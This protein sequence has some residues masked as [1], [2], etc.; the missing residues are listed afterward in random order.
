MSVPLSLSAF[1]LPPPIPVSDIATERGRLLKREAIALVLGGSLKTT[2]PYP[3][4]RAEGPPYACIKESEN[5]L[6]PASPGNHGILMVKSL[7][8]AL[9]DPSLQ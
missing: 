5:D 2:F 6:I 9:V 1:K 7:P 3:R 8:D 4:N